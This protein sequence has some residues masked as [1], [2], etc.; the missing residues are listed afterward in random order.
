VPND[1]GPGD[2]VLADCVLADCVLADCVLADRVLADCVLADCV[3]A[4]RVLADRVLADRVL[5]DISAHAA[6]V[7]ADPA[8]LLAPDNAVV[9]GMAARTALL[10]VCKTGGHAQYVKALGEMASSRR[11]TVW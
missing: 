6:S 5:A 4:D 1:R 11:P 7:P 8:R 10:R 3:L 9:V 2:G